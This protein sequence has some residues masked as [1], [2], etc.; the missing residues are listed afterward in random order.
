MERR[1]YKHCC[2]AVALPLHPVGG[3]VPRTPRIGLQKQSVCKKLG[4]DARRP[5]QLLPCPSSA[6]LALP[7]EARALRARRLRRPARRARRPGGDWVKQGLRPRP[8]SGDTSPNP[9]VDGVITLEKSMKKECGDI[10][11]INPQILF[12]L[13]VL[14]AHAHIRL[15]QIFAF[16]RLRAARASCGSP[17][18]FVKD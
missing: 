12:N 14:P 1:L 2:F 15:K 16:P 8:P 11:Y 7:S 5:H 13:L 3:R 4:L 9:R 18:Q 17:R 6:R 10:S